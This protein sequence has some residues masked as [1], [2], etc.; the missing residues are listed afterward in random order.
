MFKLSLVAATVAII[1]STTRRL[2][3][4]V[5]PPPERFSSVGTLPTTLEQSVQK[6]ARRVLPPPDIP[7]RTVIL[8]STNHEGVSQPIMKIGVWAPLLFQLSALFYNRFS[9]D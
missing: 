5:V 4:V 6:L 8:F 1:K 2:L 9:Q 3:S 7:F